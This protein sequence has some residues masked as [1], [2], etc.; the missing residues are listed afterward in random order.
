LL[1]RLFIRRAYARIER[2]VKVV[3]EK[4]GKLA[5]T[6]VIVS[7]IRL[8]LWIVAALLFLLALYYY[9]SQ[10]MFAFPGSRGLAKDLIAFL[11]EPLISLALGAVALIP[12]ILVLAVIYFL[13]RYILK[14]IRLIFVN[15]DIGVIHLRGFQS[16]WTWPTYR[17][18]R[19]VVII[20]AIVVAY[21]YI[22]GSGTTAFQGISIFL[23]IVLSLG[24]SSVISNVLAGLFVIYRRSIN[25]GDLIEVNGYVGR[26]ESIVMLETILRTPMNELVSIPNSKLLSSE[27]RNYSKPG[28]AGGV[29]I[30]VKV[31]IGYEEPQRKIEEMLME[32]ATR[33]SGL[34]NQPPPVVLRSELA[35]FAVV[36]ELR[37]SPQKIDAF[38][39]VKSALYANILDVFNERRV[40]IMTPAYETDPAEPKIA[41]IE[42]PEPE[43]EPE[44][45]PQPPTSS[46]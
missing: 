46:A 2:W 1:F 12:D 19:V 38:P 10:V 23:G 30:S 40:Q 11:T 39:V 27:L 3:E 45:Q 26:V 31:G 16:A 15:I 34:R 13:T 18:L 44:P 32:A 33:T 37:V 21:P 42:T 14:I 29:M 41:P 43:P 6:D 25:E 24:S 36:Y 17:I 20:F 5:E 28:R 22:P 8:T 9:L 7:V 4:T 35:D